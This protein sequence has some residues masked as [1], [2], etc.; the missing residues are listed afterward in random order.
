MDRFP[1]AAE[2]LPVEETV[3][4]LPMDLDL[5]RPEDIFITPSACG[6]EQETA[7]EPPSKKPKR[8]ASEKQK[9]H[10]AKAREKAAAARKAK[11]ELSRPDPV[12]VAEPVVVHRAPDKDDF[13][14]WR[15]HYSRHQSEAE[16]ERK[17]AEALAQKEA[18]KML[19]MEEVIERRVRE[20]LMAEASQKKAPDILQPR[21]PAVV[22]D[23]WGRYF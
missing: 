1:D 23:P 17:A 8:V 14:E 18:E 4:P 20:K 9:A 19:A 6:P 10:L 13:A 2:P 3:T 12:P 22:A 7:A 21:P 15:K 11:A 5:L 16:A